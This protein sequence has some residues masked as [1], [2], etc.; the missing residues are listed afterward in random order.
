MHRI[1]I[2]FPSGDL[3]YVH[4]VRNFAE[5][6]YRQIQLTG[7]GT[8]QDIDR[9]TDLVLVEIHHS[10]DLGTVRGILKKEIQRHHY[11]PDAVVQRL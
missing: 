11:G 2:N 10:R 3:G 8:V 6:L 9:A 4:R 1:S 5:D 7:L